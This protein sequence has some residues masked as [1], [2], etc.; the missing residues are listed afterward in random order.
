MNIW[1]FIV[2][3]YFSYKLRKKFQRFYVNFATI[4][5]ESRIHPVYVKGSTA[6]KEKC[7]HSMDRTPECFNFFN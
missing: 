4:E 7:K 5:Q 2:T 6:R 1:D 3:N